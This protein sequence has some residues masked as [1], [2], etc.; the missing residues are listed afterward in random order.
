MWHVAST[1][2]RVVLHALCR[3]RRVRRSNLM[4]MVLLRR[5]RL[6]HGNRRSVTLLNVLLLCWHGAWLPHRRAWL[7]RRTSTR[8][9]R[10][11]DRRVPP[12]HH[13]RR[14][15]SGVSCSMLS[16]FCFG[17]CVAHRCLPVVR[18]STR[19]HASAC[20]TDPSPCSSIRRR[21]SHAAIAL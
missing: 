14:G 19:H 17:R 12:R 18:K 21:R 9:H 6:V 8:R 16:L 4:S 15:D 2:S 11:V 7:P 13:V 1:G 20:R 10:A 3:M 5:R